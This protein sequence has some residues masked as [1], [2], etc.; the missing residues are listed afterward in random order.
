MMTINFRDWADNCSGSIRR[1]S[2][3][4]A[5]FLTDGDVP[6]AAQATALSV[7]DHLS[8][9]ARVDYGRRVRASASPTRLLAIAINIT[10]CKILVLSFSPYH[11]LHLIVRRSLIR[12]AALR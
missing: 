9:T 8:Q 10:S 11:P 12:R 2:S 1:P 3:I 6:P 7:P 5:Y 4:F